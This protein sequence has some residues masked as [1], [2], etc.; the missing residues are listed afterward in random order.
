[1]NGLGL[2]AATLSALTFLPQLLHTWRTRSG[3]GVSGFMLAVALSSMVLWLLY[4]LYLGSLPIILANAVSLFFTLL[5]AY[6]TWYFGR[7]AAPPETP[8]PG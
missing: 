4:G 5:L 2:V 7:Q 6:L 3:R 8:G 1:M